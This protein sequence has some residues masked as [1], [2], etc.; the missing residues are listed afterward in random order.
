MSGDSSEWISLRQAAEILGVHP[1]TVRNWA[2]KGEL[3]S[4]RTPGGHR[5]FRKAELLQYAHSQSEIQPGEVQ[6]IIQNAL[7][8]A[9]MEVGDGMLNSVPWY[10]AMSEET[11]AAMRTLG[12]A[13]LEALRAYLASGAPDEQLAQAIRMGKEYAAVLSQDGLTLPQAMRGF[14]YFGEFIINSILTWSEITPPRSAPE[15]ANLLRQVN[16]FM[17]TMLLSLAEYYEEE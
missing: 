4:R 2:D 8:Q 12:R 3:T 10:A 14:F 13:L 1:A 9:R 5:R 16:N 11:R 17:N 7:G 6:V 15:W